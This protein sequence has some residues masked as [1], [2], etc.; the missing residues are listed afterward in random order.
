MILTLLFFFQ[1][2]LFSQ[3]Y[4]S[5]KISPYTAFFLTLFNEQTVDSKGANI[6][7]NRFSVKKINNLPYVNAF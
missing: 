5:G 2:S 6:L 7:Q 3:A 4:K 1:L